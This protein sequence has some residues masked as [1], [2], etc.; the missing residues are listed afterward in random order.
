MGKDTCQHCGGTGQRPGNCSDPKK[1]S[2]C[3]GTGKRQ[4]SMCGGSG[5]R[6]GGYAA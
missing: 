3:F 1:C 4:C 2:Q 6:T 5:K